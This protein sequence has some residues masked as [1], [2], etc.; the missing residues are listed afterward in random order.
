M[1][2]YSSCTAHHQINDLEIIDTTQIAVDDI[3]ES[4]HLAD[5]IRSIDGVREIR[6]N[7]R[8]VTIHHRRDAGDEIW[9]V[10]DKPSPTSN[11]R[12]TVH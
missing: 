7:D 8:E 6:W 10:V 5:R 9:R 4:A 3:T 11:P 1:S 12:I 2:D